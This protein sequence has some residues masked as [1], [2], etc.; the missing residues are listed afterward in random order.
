MTTPRRNKEN[1][2]MTIQ[3]FIARIEIVKKIL[4]KGKKIELARQPGRPGDS[5]IDR[6]V[7]GDVA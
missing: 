7:E 6:I 3:K 4:W 1:P 5:L 2:T